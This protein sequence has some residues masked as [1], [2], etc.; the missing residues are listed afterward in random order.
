VSGNKIKLFLNTKN[1]NFSGSLPNKSNV[2]SGNVTV[3]V[4][5]TISALNIGSVVTGDLYNPDH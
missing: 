3:F 5:L 1:P 2:N 4:S